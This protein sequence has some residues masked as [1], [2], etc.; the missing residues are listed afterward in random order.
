MYRFPLL[1]LALS[2]ALCLPS[3]A[4]AKRRR[5][6]RHRVT[7]SLPGVVHGGPWTEPTYADS[8]DGDSI[9]GDDPTVR[10]IAIRALGPYNGSVVVVDSSTGRILSILNQRLALG[11]SYQPCSTFKVAVALAA[12]SEKVIDQDNTIQPAS[13]GID[14]TNALAHSNNHFFANLG[15]ELGF[16]KVSSYAHEFGYGEKAG[17]NIIGEGAGHFPLEP[18]PNGGVSMLTSFGEEISQTPL[19]LAALMSAIANGGTL[20]CLQYPRN[21][22]EVASF[23]P[24]VRRR[25]SIEAPIL[26]IIPGLQAAVEIG[27]AR[28]A[29]QEQ[30][31]AGKTGTCSENHTH[32]GWFGAF[33]SVGRRLVVVV[34]LRG[35]REATGPRAAAIAGRIYHQL[36]EANYL[37]GPFRGGPSAPPRPRLVISATVLAKVLV[38]ICSS[39]TLILSWRRLRG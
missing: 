15:R 30:P 2:L 16:E 4:T 24:K 21:A 11:I 12:L 26:G 23:T 1:C 22:K 18:P 14:L 10:R 13:M 28:A 25:L 31:I 3:S 6:S 35:G 39:I 33:N 37:A 34:L 19:Q 20:Y 38:L 17:L 7:S 5:P 29:R 32:L 36:S 8:T 9:T 27:T